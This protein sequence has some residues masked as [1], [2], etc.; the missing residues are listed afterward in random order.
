MKF[1]YLGTAAYEGVPS[2]FCKCE[3]CKYS[4]KAKGRNLRSRTQAIIDNKIL[5]DFPADAFAHSMHYGIDYTDINTCIITHFH[6]DHLY[7]NDMFIRSPIKGL[8][9]KNSPLTVYASAP[10]VDRI[11]TLATKLDYTMGD[12]LVTETVVPNK[13]F[14]ADG[15]KITPLKADHDPEC[16]PVFYIIEKDGKSILYAHD[17][18]YFPEETWEY[19]EKN[20]CKFNMVSFDCTCGILPIRSGHMGFDACVEARDRLRKI[21]AIT[22]DTVCILNH[23]SHNGKVHYDSMCKIAEEKGF[24]VSYDGMTVDL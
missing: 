2:L 8:L 1:Q 18:G 10:S 22:N 21:G 14:C 9:D 15:Y 3:V 5:I 11:E 23:F 7:P 24:I 16:E 12:Y 19:I 13:P 4:R 20:S 17:T 6:S